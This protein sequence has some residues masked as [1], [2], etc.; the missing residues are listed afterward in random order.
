M[1]T[2]RAVLITSL[3]S[4]SLAGCA[5]KDNFIPQPDRDMATV[6]GQHMSGIGDGKLIDTRSLIRRPMIEGDVELSD[7]VRTEKT[8][9][10]SKF[11]MLPN[12]KMYM[13]VGPHLA[14]QDEVPIPGYLTEFRMWKRTTMR[15]PGAF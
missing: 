14:T 9:L 10:Q 7:D 1:Q 5:N 15:F 4:L 2:S 12:P 13:F 6:Y 3:I 11:R 8:Q